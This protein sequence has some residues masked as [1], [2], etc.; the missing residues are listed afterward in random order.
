MSAESQT[1]IATGD[2]SLFDC[3]VFRLRRGVTPPENRPT[4]N[5]DDVRCRGTD[6]LG[7]LQDDVSRCSLLFG[8]DPSARC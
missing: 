8:S 3:A 1:T 2:L 5:R 6:P 7:L 4:V